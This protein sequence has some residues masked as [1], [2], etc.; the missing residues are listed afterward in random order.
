MGMELF[1]GY[2]S[3]YGYTVQDSSKIFCGNLNLNNTVFYR[4]HYCSNNFNDILKAMMVLFELTPC[5][6]ILNSHTYNI[7]FCCCYQQGGTTLLFYLPHLLCS[8]C[9]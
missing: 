9:A 2:I 1:A 7:W 3:F 4:E 5:N 6:M 8:D